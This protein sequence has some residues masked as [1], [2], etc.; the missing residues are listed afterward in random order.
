MLDRSVNV[1][2]TENLGEKALQKIQNRYV[3]KFKIAEIRTE[4]DFQKLRF[5]LREFFGDGAEGLE[6]RILENI[7][8]SNTK[9]E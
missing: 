9:S 1:I 6:S 4:E 8:R 3:K 5:V 7:N 2:I